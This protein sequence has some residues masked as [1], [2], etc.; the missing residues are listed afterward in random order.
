MPV[1]DLQEAEADMAESE[2]FPGDRDERD[3]SNHGDGEEEEPAACGG[4]QRT[5]PQC[6]FELVLSGIRSE[7]LIQR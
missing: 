2:G 7:E 4:D 6:Q 1:T 3:N 5:C